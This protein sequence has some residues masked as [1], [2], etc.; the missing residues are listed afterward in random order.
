[1]AASGMQIAHVTFYLGIATESNTATRKPSLVWHC[2]RRLLPLPQRHM[3]LSEMHQRALSPRPHKP[4]IQPGSND[5]TRQ[6]DDSPS[7][8]LYD[9]G[10]SARGN[11]LDHPRHE[12]IHDFP[13]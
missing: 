7:P 6:R 13:L 10:A 5:R 11:S 2:E 12:L 4:V 1:M 9:L 3:P 8:L